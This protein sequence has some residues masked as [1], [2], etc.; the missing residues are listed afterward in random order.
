ME[1]IF[2]K[3]LKD[4]AEV[5]L[6]HLRNLVHLSIKQSLYPDECKKSFFQK[7]FHDFSTILV[8]PVVPKMI[9]ETLPIH[10]QEHLDIN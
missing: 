7:G 1:R 2:S 3:F 8:L 4:G 10:T 9:K 6:S 5:L